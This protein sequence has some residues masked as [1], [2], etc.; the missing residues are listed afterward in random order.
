M[1]FWQEYHRNDVLSFSVLP[2]KTE[3]M[4]ICPVTD[5]VNFDHLFKVIPAKFLQSYFFPFSIQ[6]ILWEGSLGPQKCSIFHQTFICPPVLAP[7]G[8]F[9][10]E[11][12]IMVE[13]EWLFSNSI[14]PSTFI[15]WHS[16]VRKTYSFPFTHSFIYSFIHRTMSQILCWLWRHSEEVKYLP[17]RTLIIK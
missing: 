1:Y 10:P 16:I 11:I 9:L 14:I 7:I 6:G 5:G 12:I 8:L 13:V 17:L 3:V 4:R 2:I 15:S